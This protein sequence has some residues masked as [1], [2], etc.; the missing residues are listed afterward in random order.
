MNQQLKQ[1]IDKEIEF[2]VS[3]ISSKSQDLSTYRKIIAMFT[4]EKIH[5]IIDQTL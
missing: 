3:E 4:K 2:M 1:K 5:Q